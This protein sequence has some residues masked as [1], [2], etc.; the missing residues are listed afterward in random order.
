MSTEASSY[1]TCGFVLIPLANNA[2]LWNAN[3]IEEWRTEFDLCNKEQKLHGLSQTGV[4]TKL[5]L[6]DDCVV[7]SSV[8]WEEWRAEVGE[9][10]TLVMIVGALL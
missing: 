7:L 5:Q 8:K 6:T 10:G 9:I 3:D 2:T 1:P 4:L